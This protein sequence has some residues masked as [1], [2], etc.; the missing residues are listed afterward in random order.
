MGSPA[1]TSGGER[2]DEN[3]PKSNLSD[4]ESVSFVCGIIILSVFGNLDKCTKPTST[5]YIPQVSKRS[6]WQSL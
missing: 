3:E 2:R 5:E 1:L 6:C 4:S